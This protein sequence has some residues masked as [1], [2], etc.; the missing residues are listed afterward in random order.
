MRTKGSVPQVFV[1]AA[2]AQAAR[3]DGTGDAQAQLGSPVQP[4]VAT[5]V[6]SGH[7]EGCIKVT[8]DVSRLT[9]W[10]RPAWLSAELQMPAGRDGRVVDCAQVTVWGPERP[11][12]MAINPSPSSA[13]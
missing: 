12:L 3:T 4:V 5:L 1:A 6:L 9:A 10:K 13:D 2:L 7:G 11:R 8:F